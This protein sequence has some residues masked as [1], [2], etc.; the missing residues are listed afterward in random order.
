VQGSELLCPTECRARGGGQRAG[1]ADV[2]RS[3][4]A[5]LP[6]RAPVLKTEAGGTTLS[7]AT[8]RKNVPGATMGARRKFYG[9]TQ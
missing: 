3:D 5:E 2:S 9:N 1:T 8:E 7:N 4:E 6:R